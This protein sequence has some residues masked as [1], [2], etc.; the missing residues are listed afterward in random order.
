MPVPARVVLIA[1]NAGTKMGGEAIKAYQYFQWLLDNGI[2][3][4]LVTHERN[5]QELAQCLPSDRVLWVEETPLQAF[6]WHSIVLRPLLGMY[7]HLTATRLIRNFDR[8]TT[9]VHYVCPISPVTLRFP[10]RGYRIVIG[11]LNGNIG[12]PAAF[13]NRL[14]RKQRV[15]ETLYGLTQR[16]SGVLFGDKRRGLDGACVGW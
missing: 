7:F 16:A 5:R 13:R 11:P 6:F 9:L 14:S 1:P 15:A 10:P 12:Y 3:A 8:V 4:L 2:D